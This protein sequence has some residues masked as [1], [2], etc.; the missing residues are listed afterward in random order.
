MK[1]F[2]AL[3]ALEILGFASAFAQTAIPARPADPNQ[4]MPAQP[5]ETPVPPPPTPAKPSKAD[6]SES[7]APSSAS[8]NAP[9]E[10][11]PA[12]PVVLSIMADS[13]LKAVI[14][15][16]AQAWADSLDNSPQ[17]PLTLTNAGTMR[18]KIESGSGQWDLVIDADIDDVK[19][20]TEKGSLSS[21]SQRSLARNTLVVYGKKAL[22][23]DDELDW[24]DLVGSEWKKV[25][26]GN[27]D[28]VASG[29]AAKRALQ[30]HGLTG[31]ETK[32]LYLYAP[33]ESRALSLVEQEKAD[34]VFL[35]K[36]DLTGVSL[37][38]FEALT[39]KPEDSPPIFYT[40][41]VVSGSKNA[42]QAQAFILFCT[43][44][45]ARPIWAKYGF[46]N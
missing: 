29:R 17:V 6:P 13:S 35:Y 16:L 11:A 2:T 24:F 43:S 10:A 19:A 31:D 12:G 36:S 37:P 3:I 21:D 9:A 41:A 42:A 27:P 1:F 46:E 40:A 33:T 39:P 30:K 22:L 5:I 18:S 15:E 7:P 32:D 44:E 45:A 4:A 8:T 25:A 28:Q 14:Q 23:K 20:M 34:A 38:G 26:M